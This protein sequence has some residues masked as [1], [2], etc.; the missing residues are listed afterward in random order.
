MPMSGRVDGDRRARTIQAGLY[1][2]IEVMR[3]SRP[4][5]SNG[6]RLRGLDRG[7][8]GAMD[9]VEVGGLHLAYRRTGHGRS[10]MFVHGGAEDSRAWTPQ[11]E[12]LSDE[13]TVVAWDEPGAGGSGD[14]PDDFGLSDYA[15]CLAGM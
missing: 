15:D 4:L 2:Q 11:L 8:V 5:A 10:V 7:T 1:P 13:F 9:T 12:A 14:V 6:L 3:A